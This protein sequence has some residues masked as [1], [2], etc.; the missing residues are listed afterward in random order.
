MAKLWG[1]LIDIVILFMI[2]WFFWSIIRFCI[3]GC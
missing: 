2:G 3:G 1:C